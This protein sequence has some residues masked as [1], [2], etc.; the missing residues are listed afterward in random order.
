MSTYT[1]DDDGADHHNADFTSIQ[2]AVNAAAPGDTIKVFPGTYN[3]NVNIPKDSLK[4]Q[5]EHHG[6]AV[7]RGSAAPTQEAVV[8]INGAH[9]VEFRGFKIAPQNTAY[10]YDLLVAGGGSA[11]LR[12]NWVTGATG[13]NATVGIGVL[14]SSADVR[15]NQVDNYQKNGIIIDG[16]SATASVNRNVVTG[17]GPTATAA[18][19]GIQV[20]NGAKADVRQNTVSKNIYSPGTVSATGILLTGAGT[21]T[22]VSENNVFQ[23][24]INIALDTT[25]GATVEKNRVSAATYEGITLSGSSN[26][27]IR[28]NTAEGNM[29]NGISLFDGSNNNVVEKNDSNNNGRDGISLGDADNNQIS[30][31]KAQNNGGDGIYLDSASTGN[32]VTQNDLHNNARYDAEDESVGTGTAGTA[33]FWDKNECDTANPEGICDHPGKKHDHGHGHGKHPKDHAPKDAKFDR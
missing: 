23:N 32:R 18:Q 4:L 26:N 19:N 2:A 9:N 7:I 12:E 13:G 10:T 33:N 27:R 25:N 29:E 3:E 11:Q 28:Q 21:G 8:K 20:S 31:N 16:L 5:A 6:D 15:D 22:S 14:D 24:D 17:A 30:Q 1:V